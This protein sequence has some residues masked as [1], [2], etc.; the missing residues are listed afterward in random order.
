[1]KSR[2]DKLKYVSTR[3]WAEKQG[4]SQFNNHLTLPDKAVV[5]KPKA[6][7]VLIDILP[8]EVGEG[9]PNAEPG[10]L[11]WTRVYY[12]HRGIGAN[13]EMVI[14][15]LKTAKEP[16][17]ICKF[18]QGL[19]KKASEDHEDTIKD[20]APRERQLVN[21]INLKEPDK[22]IQLWD[23]STYNF[24]NV[25]AGVLR[26]ADEDDDWDGFYHLE[27]GLS[28][29]VGLVEESFSGTKFISAE[30][31]YFKPRREDYDDSVLKKVFCLDELVVPLEY[32]A[33]KKQFLETSE[34]PEEDED[35]PRAGKRKRVVEEE[36][37]DE[38]P[39]KKKRVVEEEE[40]EAPPRRKRPVQSDED[41]DNDGAPPD[42]DDEPA[43]KKKRRVEAEDEDEAPAKKKKPAADDDDDGWDDFDAPKGKGKR[44]D[45][46]QPEL[47]LKKKRAE[48]EED[49]D[50]DEAP[51]RKSQ[52][53]FAKQKGDK[54]WEDEGEEAPEEDD[55]DAPPRKKKRVV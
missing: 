25:L 53:R 6:G 1:M 32:E 35:E 47:P 55:E 4:Q 3:K 11:F 46:D 37:E 34:D 15:P 45:P 51:P 7:S 24:G 30:N 54:G 39:P 28:L 40:D 20:L 13:Q 26:N 17:P 36:D 2:S 42:E 29:K 43:P 49:E 48:P 16:C 5:F 14:C 50:E 21:L 31:I 10:N 22:G 27:G 19:M 12:V 9:N 23:V 41:D 52:G 8:Y 38:A 44:E 18:R 33:L